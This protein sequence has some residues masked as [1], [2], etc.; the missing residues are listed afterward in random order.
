VWTL[1]QRGIVAAT[2]AAAALTADLMCIS[3]AVVC[4]CSCHA[5]RSLMCKPVALACFRLLLLLLLLLH[6]T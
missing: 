5:L 1:L 4:S 2:A 6:W 3:A